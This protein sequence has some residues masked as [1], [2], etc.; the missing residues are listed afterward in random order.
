MWVEDHSVSP[1]TIAHSVRSSSARYNCLK[2]NRTRKKVLQQQAKQVAK[3]RPF[4][5]DTPKHNGKPWIYQRGL[6]KRLKKRRM[7]D[8]TDY[9]AVRRTDSEDLNFHREVVLETDIQTQKTELKGGGKRT[10][11]GDEKHNA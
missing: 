4:T 6:K 3:S 5:V 10:A 1:M 9:N 7:D 11:D 8:Q 2:F